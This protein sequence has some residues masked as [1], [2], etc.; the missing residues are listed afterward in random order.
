M[1][2]PPGEAGLRA[3]SER[4]AQGETRIRA[5]LLQ[6]HAGDRRALLT[7]A[8]T[9]LNALRQEDAR[10]AVSTAYLSA[11]RDVAGLARRRRAAVPPFHPNCTCTISA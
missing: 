1:R 8:L 5:L 2:E 11:Y 4:F 9:I 7:E 3:L 10:G 6:V